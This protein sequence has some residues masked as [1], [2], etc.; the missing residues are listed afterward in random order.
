MVQAGPASTVSAL[1]LASIAVFWQGLEY[2]VERPAAPPVPAP[3]SLQEVI[4]ALRKA[5]PSRRRRRST[6]PQQAATTTPPATKGRKPKVGPRRRRRRTASASSAG[7][8]VAALLAGLASVVA[9]FG[10][11]RAWEPANPQ[12]LADLAPGLGDNGAQSP[13]RPRPQRS[14]RP[15]GHL[16]DA[17]ILDQLA[18]AEYRR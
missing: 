6:Q 7:W 1:V 3:P 13:P 10:L 5:R 4:G 18:A 16:G 8:W 14:A 12:A 15:S 9:F 2:Y 17:S 11:R